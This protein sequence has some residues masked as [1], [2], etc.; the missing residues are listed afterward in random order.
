MLCFSFGGGDARGKTT[1][2]EQI[3]LNIYEVY[4]EASEAATNELVI[5]REGR[6]QQ[7]RAHGHHR[8]ERSF[9]LALKPV[10]RVRYLCLVLLVGASFS[11][12]C[13]LSFLGEGGRE[14]A[15]VAAA[16][17]RVGS[18]SLSGITFCADTSTWQCVF[19]YRMIAVLR[20][21]RARLWCVRG[22]F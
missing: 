9:L 10:C 21:R 6:L 3:C 18:R 1:T 17:L 15:L 4:C 13:V 2:G 19:S 20:V 11:V 22:Y 8:R 5:S 16:M 12:R 7:S 14:E